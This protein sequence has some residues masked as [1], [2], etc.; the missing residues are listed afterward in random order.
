MKRTLAIVFA[1]ILVL[2]LFAGCSTGSSESSTAPESTAPESSAPESTEPT[3]DYS[4]YFKGENVTLIVPWSAGGGSDTG[5]R[6]LIPY[7]EDILGCTITVENLTGGSGW[8][9]WEK[10]LTGDTDG[11]TWAMVNWPTLFPGYLNPDYNRNYNLDSFQLIANHVT[12]W[13]VIVI[14]KDETRFSTMEELV[15]YAKNNITTFGTTGSGT[16]DH[17][18]ML[19]LNDVLGTQFEMVASNGWSDNNAAIQGGHIDVTAANVGEVYSLVN[20]GTLKVLCVFSNDPVE[21]IPD[22]PVFNSLGITDTSITNSS[23]RGF[24]MKA[25]VDPGIV[26]VVQDAFDQAIN[27]PSH[28]EEMYALGL[29]VDYMNAED[30]RVHLVNDEKDI[31]GMADIFGWNIS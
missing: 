8:V 5:A 18:L 15:D 4:D 10:L 3:V 6:K 14:N 27:N 9:G 21:L 19:K 29:A 2:A 1:L 12:D 28:I 13:S 31:L 17:I 25:G 11:K 30:Y 16:D 24:A 26:K 22:V 23:Q 7:V 20:D